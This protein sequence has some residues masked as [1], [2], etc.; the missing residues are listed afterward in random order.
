MSGLHSN[1]NAENANMLWFQAY[2]SI[3]H[4]AKGVWFYTFYDAEVFESNESLVF[5]QNNFVPGT[6]PSL[7]INWQNG[8]MC[9]NGQFIRNNF[10]KSYKNFVSHLARELRY[11]SDFGYL[12]SDSRTIA[13][14]TNHAD[15][16][17]IV[18]DSYL[19]ISNSLP[20]SD[21]NQSLTLVNNHSNPIPQWLNDF[22]QIYDEK[23]SENYG[24]R[25]IIK[26]NS[27]GDVVMIIVNPL[28]ATVSVSLDFSQMTHHKIRDSN[29]VKMFFENGYENIPP[30]PNQYKRNRESVS[31]INF[32]L[33]KQHDKYYE[34]GKEL[35]L[36]FPPYDVKVL[37]FEN[38]AIHP[39]VPSKPI[40]G[41][42]K[43]YFNIFP[44]P[45]PINKLYI[46]TQFERCENVLIAIT[47]VYG[48]NVYQRNMG[49]PNFGRNSYD[50]N[51]STLNKGIYFIKCF[52]GN[53]LHAVK[54]FI[55]SE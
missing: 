24:L 5:L 22:D 3:V 45:N 12:D 21:I 33:I 32:K 6:D 47:D 4:G 18:P 19:Y 40:P 9:F 27:E 17:G 28:K 2:A 23:T 46:D 36:E 44:N 48:G 37:K 52:E 14:K 54:K 39:K 49:V 29:G 16:C 35:T 26:E 31:P 11:L 20:F 1:L 38:L 30:K 7:P 10:P 55:K 43:I 41:S 53:S 25:Y 8:G 42:T 51:I 50:I 34:N 13:S 15:T